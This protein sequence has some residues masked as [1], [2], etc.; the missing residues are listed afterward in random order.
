MITK[1]YSPFIFFFLCFNLFCDGCYL[2]WLV[3]GTPPLGLSSYLV[4]TIQYES[5]ALPLYLVRTILINKNKIIIIIKNGGINVV[6]IEQL[7]SL[8]LQ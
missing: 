3:F 8:V 6:T 4:R 5:Y 2:N 7:P 1:L